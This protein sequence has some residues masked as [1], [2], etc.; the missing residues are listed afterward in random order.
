MFCFFFRSLSVS[1]NDRIFDMP[2][3]L[4]SSLIYAWAEQQ[5]ECDSMLFFFACLLASSLSLSRRLIFIIALIFL[6]VC[7]SF[8]FVSQ[9]NC[10]FFCVCLFDQ[11]FGFV[12]FLWLLFCCYFY[13]VRKIIGSDF[14]TFIQRHSINLYVRL[15]RVFVRLAFGNCVCVC[16]R[17][18]CTSVNSQFS[19]D[20]F[21]FRFSISFDSLL[22]VYF[23]DVVALCFHSL[24]LEML[25]HINRCVESSTYTYLFAAAAV[26]LVFQH[27]KSIQQ[28]R[29][30]FV[31]LLYCKCFVCHSLFE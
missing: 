23:F 2:K 7:F 18:A 10:D 6:F 26:C 12:S 1:G 4:A 28:N 16:A 17:A 29:L 24:L 25:T 19:T 22:F 9:I 20:Y 3:L 15:I 13:S 8:R 11:S 14:Q 5:N 27:L 21:L 30:N 31:L